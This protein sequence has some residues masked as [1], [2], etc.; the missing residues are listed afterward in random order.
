MHLRECPRSYHLSYA[1]LR[2]GGGV[3]TQRSHS[4]QVSSACQAWWLRGENPCS[5]TSSLQGLQGLLQGLESGVR[6]SKRQ[7]IFNSDYYYNRA[8]ILENTKIKL[9][10]FH[11]FKDSFLW[12]SSVMWLINVVLL[13]L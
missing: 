2:L 7:V 6:Q 4:G 10:L 9:L 5:L 12:V 3:S 13:D 8:I 11:I 1:S